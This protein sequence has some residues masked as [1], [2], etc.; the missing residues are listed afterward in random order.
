MWRLFVSVQVD[1]DSTKTTPKHGYS[2]MWL[3]SNQ[4]W[5]QE[6]KKK[7]KAQFKLEVMKNKGSRQTDWWREHR[8]ATASVCS[9]T[10]KELFWRFE[11]GSVVSTFEPFRCFVKVFWSRELPEKT[12]TRFDKKTQKH[13]LIQG[14]LLAFWLLPYFH[15]YVTQWTFSWEEEGFAFSLFKWGNARKCCDLHQLCNIT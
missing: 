8:S 6:K 14:H 13:F 4:L 2:Q 9:N 12:S 7:K 15:N 11:Q 1:G 10:Y 5:S 3:N